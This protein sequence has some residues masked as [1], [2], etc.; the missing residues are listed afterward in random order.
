[1]DVNGDDGDILPVAALE[2]SGLDIE[3]VIK[4]QSE[5]SEWKLLIDA[6]RCNT[7]SS[8]KELEGKKVEI[9][10]LW[11]LWNQLVLKEGVLYQKFADSNQESAP[12]RQLVVPP[13]LQSEVLREVHEGTFGG[14]LGED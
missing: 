7:R 5:D 9:R 2:L 6:R 11:Q 4:K 12:V 3:E 14:H 8:T 13:V 1:M 10:R